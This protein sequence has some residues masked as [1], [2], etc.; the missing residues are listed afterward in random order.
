MYGNGNV[1]QKDIHSLYLIKKKENN[2]KGSWALKQALKLKSSTGIVTATYLAYAKRRQ[3]FSI[4]KK[5]HFSFFNVIIYP[6]IVA[7]S[8]YNFV[9]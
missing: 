3:I 2:N 8:E 4:S 1:L 5:R 6:Q 7:I 9:P